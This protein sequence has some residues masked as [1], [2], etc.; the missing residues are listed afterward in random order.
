MQY[1]ELE[2]ACDTALSRNAKKPDLCVA[3][4]NVIHVSTENN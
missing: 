4:L 2:S 1:A 3:F